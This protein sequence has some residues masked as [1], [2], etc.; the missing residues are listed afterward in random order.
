MKKISI[1]ALLGAT[2]TLAACGQ[3]A[4]ERGLTGGATGMVVAG[5]VGAV[6]GATAGASGAVKVK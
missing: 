3:N 1:A 2:V 4:V 5:P 6:A